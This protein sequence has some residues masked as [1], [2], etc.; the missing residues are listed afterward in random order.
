MQTSRSGHIEMLLTVFSS[1][2]LMRFLVRNGGEGD[3][4]V[5]HWILLYKEFGS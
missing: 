5:Q 3:L 2:E 4:E 1:R